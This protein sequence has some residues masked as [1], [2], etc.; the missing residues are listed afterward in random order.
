MTQPA[1]PNQSRLRAGLRLTVVTAAILAVVAVFALL[2]GAL[3]K[4]DTS[5]IDSALSQGQSAQPPAFDLE[6]L[7][8]GTLRPELASLETKFA[9]G[10]ITNDDLR[11]T[12]VVLNFWASWCLPCGEEA[13]VFKAASESSNTRGILFLGVNS[14]DGRSAA[15]S[16]AREHRLTYPNIREADNS[17]A[18]AF[19]AN[20]LPETF[21]L[22]RR[23]RIVSH[24]VGAISGPQLQAGIAAARSGRPRVLN[25]GG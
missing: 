22:D 18:R 2:A 7:T 16:F 12:P 9:D 1:A 24:V 8:A 21:F 23:G 17:I 10:R 11:G 19:G 3:L 4:A 5:G 13:P 6:V 20:A 14:L 15:R 25:A